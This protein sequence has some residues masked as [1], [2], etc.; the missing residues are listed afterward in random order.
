MAEFGGIRGIVPGRWIM[1]PTCPW[2]EIQII[3]NWINI[4]VDH[5]VE[6]RLPILAQIHGHRRREVIAWY[7]D[8]WQER[9]DR[10]IAKVLY[11]NMPQYVE[12]QV[13]VNTGI[14]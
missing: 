1:E 4:E 2:A 12:S 10:L 11:E 3:V 6:K 8:E 5:D 9:H 7:N 13:E 14:K